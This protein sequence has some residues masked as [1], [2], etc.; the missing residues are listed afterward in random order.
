MQVSY[1]WQSVVALCRKVICDLVCSCLPV[2]PFPKASS[3]ISQGALLT[4]AL[5]LT[6]GGVVHGQPTALP[7]GWAELQFGMAARLILSVEVF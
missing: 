1:G 2:H 7:V 6:E 3:R 4:L 5:H